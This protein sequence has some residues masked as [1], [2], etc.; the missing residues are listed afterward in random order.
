MCAVKT[1]IFANTFVAEQYFA[2]YVVFSSSIKCLY[3]I[4]IIC[5]YIYTYILYIY[6]YIY[7]RIFQNSWKST[8]PEIVFTLLWCHQ[9][10]VVTEWKR[11]RK[12]SAKYASIYE[13]KNIFKTKFLYLHLF[14]EYVLDAYII[15][16]KQADFL[17]FFIS[18][19]FS[20]YIALSR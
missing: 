18:Y 8:W 3:I 7:I 20:S 14:E 10:S 6:I 19:T 17:C 5:I 13:L 15:N 11:T 16:K 2:N 12:S 1:N 4:C 9:C